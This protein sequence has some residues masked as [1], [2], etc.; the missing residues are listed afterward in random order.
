LII[1]EEGGTV[2]T[3]SENGFGKRT[4]VTEFPTK[5][6][7]TQGVIGMV[8]SER[9][10]ALVGAVQVQENNEIML[11]SDQGTLVRTRVSEVSTLGR[12]TQGVTLIKV[13]EGE[14]L[15]GVAPILDAVV[16]ELDSVLADEAGVIDESAD[17]SVDESNQNAE[18][19]TEE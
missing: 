11:I 4:A 16:D 12:N 3:A 9:N 19:D 18:G 13:Q 6:R 5:G 2:L 14:R 17:T 15:V 7:G 10:G 1:P 8:I